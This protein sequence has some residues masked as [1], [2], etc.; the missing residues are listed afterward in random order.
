MAGVR[1]VA[2]YCDFVGYWLKGERGWEVVVLLQVK[3]EV[4]CA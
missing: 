3:S 4:G 1:R 2:Y